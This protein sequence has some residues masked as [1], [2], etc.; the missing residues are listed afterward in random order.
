VADQTAH[1][2]VVV[3]VGRPAE[4][5]DQG[6]QRQCAVGAAAGDDDVGAGRQRS[7]D[8]KRTEIGV[9]APQIVGQRCAGE[10]FPGARLAQF[11]GDRHQIVACD[12]GDA[13]VDAGLLQHG[14]D[15]LAAA[16]WIDAA[17]VDDHA[18]LLLRERRRQPSDQ[19]NEIGR[20]PRLRLP[21]ASA[22]QQRHGDLGE[23]VHDQHVDVAAFDQLHGA[24]LGV[25]P[26]AAAATD[27]KG[28]A[29]RRLTCR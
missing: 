18:D 5:V 11:V 28:S 3:I 24:M 27:A 16:Y 10:H 22:R 6:T 21:C 4:G 8:R 20:E 14:L 19:R 9:Q 2:E 29:H 12:H 25:A 26:E 17:G 1:G 13:Q 15:G 23:I 7:C